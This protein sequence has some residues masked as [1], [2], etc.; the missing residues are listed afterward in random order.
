M[1]LHASCAAL[2]GDGVL[3]LGPS[4]AGK[5]DMV[6]RLLGRGWTLVADDQVELTED[7]EGLTAAPPGALRGMLEVRGL[8]LFRDMPVTAPARLRLAVD[9]L[10]PGQEPPRLPEPRRFAAGD[11]D[12]PRLSLAAREA[13]APDKV[14]LALDAVCGRAFCAAGAFGT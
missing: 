5:S 10:A 2:R 9:L 6:L 7:A 1:P 14:T 12:I 8:G 4:G 11:R 3:F 13:A